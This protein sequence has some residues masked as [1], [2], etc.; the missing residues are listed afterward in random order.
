[1]ILDTAAKSSAGQNVAG[2]IDLSLGAEVPVRLV[3]TAAPTP[4]AL[5]PAPVPAPTSASALSPFP[6]FKIHLN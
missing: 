2:E 1:M 6:A 5:A 3:A 4:I